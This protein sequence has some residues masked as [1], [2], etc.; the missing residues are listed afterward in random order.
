MEDAAEEWVRH[1]PDVR[2]DHQAPQLN[3]QFRTSSTFGSTRTCGNRSR[4]HRTLATVATFTG[5]IRASLVLIASVICARNAGGA[6]QSWRIGYAMIGLAASL[7]S[8]VRRSLS[9]GSVFSMPVHTEGLLKPVKRPLPAPVA[10]DRKAVRAAFE[11]AMAIAETSEEMRR[12]IVASVRAWGERR[13]DS[14]PESGGDGERPPDSAPESGG[15]DPVVEFTDHPQKHGP[16]AWF[17]NPAGRSP[18][19]FLKGG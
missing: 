16:G 14:G 3:F 1:S 12:M 10:F 5:S 18:L 9:G 13:P 11:A 17:V 15:D 7:S 2:D 6:R 8:R 19:G 4:G